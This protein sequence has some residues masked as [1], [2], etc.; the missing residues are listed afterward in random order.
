MLSIEK[1]NIVDGKVTFIDGTHI[2]KIKFD[3][4]DAEDRHK[5]AEI[6]LTSGTQE[7]LN[8]AIHLNDSSQ[9]IIFNVGD[10]PLKKYCQGKAVLKC[11]IPISRK[12]F[13]QSVSMG[14][15]AYKVPGQLI[16]VKEGRADWDDHR[17]L[18]STGNH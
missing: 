18:F 7:D 4:S 1:P 11:S 5:V 13:E 8:F 2:S 12:E 16:Q 6:T 17:A 14:V 15:A 9:K 3:A 10:F